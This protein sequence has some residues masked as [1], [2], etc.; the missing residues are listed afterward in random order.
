MKD[1]PARQA[2]IDELLSELATNE[3]LV[4]EKNFAYR[5]RL[6]SDEHHFD[7]RCNN[8]FYGELENALENRIQSMDANA[9]GE[10]LSFCQLGP[11]FVLPQFHSI[12]F[13]VTELVGDTPSTSLEDMTIG[14]AI[15]DK[16]RAFLRPYV[17]GHLYENVADIHVH[18]DAPVYLPLQRSACRKFDEF[19]LVVVFVREIRP[20]IRIP[21][22]Q[23]VSWTTTHSRL[24]HG[25]YFSNI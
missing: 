14:G 4:S 6:T 21:M 8:K 25:P 20:G 2:S 24:V 11:L 9:R 18:I 22:R 19:F 23:D 10:D 12:H 15:Y 1:S 16:V 5:K 13:D 7:N 17:Q 3:H